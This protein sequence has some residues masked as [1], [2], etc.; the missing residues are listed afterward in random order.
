M[1]HSL[2][3]QNVGPAPAMDLNLAP[4][5]N[6]LTGD[7]GLGKTF[8]L[9]VAWFGLTRCWPQ[10]L[11]PG[12]SSGALALP[13]DRS[14]EALLTFAADGQQ[15]EST[16]DFRFDREDE[17][18]ISE[19]GRP[20]NPGLV[21]YAVADGAFALWDP[22]RNTTRKGS[23]SGG[24]E[25][26]RAFVFSSQEVWWGMVA[27]ADRHSWLCDGLIRD[28]ANWQRDNGAPFAQ[29]QQ[30]L[31]VLSPNESRPLR[32]GPLQR[33]RSD[34]TTMYPTVVGP[35]DVPVPVVHASSG[36]RR[37]LAWAYMLVWA[38]QEHQQASQLLAKPPSRQMLVLVDEVEAHLHPSW[39]RRVVRALLQVVNTLHQQAAV[40]L[41]LAT[42]SPLV[43]ASAEPQFDGDRDKWWDLDWNPRNRQVELTERPFERFGDA[44]SWLRSKA[45]DQS[46]TGSL[47]RE[48]TLNKAREAISKGERGEASSTGGGAAS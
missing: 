19:A 43:M 31:K 30:V 39:Q 10:E 37:I 47:E 1:L 27:P 46:G 33:L 11:N 40:Q 29:L 9:N 5:L 7:N 25:K 15:Q 2:H 28:W 38:W 44:N 23:S 41:L 12:L 45:F 20:V 36:V 3:L 6:L 4:R 32:P 16:V 26:R 48:Q 35:D 8:L 42:H 17:T 14:Q 24:R 18:W 21:L 34:T 13:R 22:A